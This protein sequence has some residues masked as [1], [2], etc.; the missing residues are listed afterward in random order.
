MRF[1]QNASDIPSH[2]P[3]SH[4]D[5]DFQVLLAEYSRLTSTISTTSNS[6]TESPSVIPVLLRH[7]A[8]TPS[9]L[10]RWPFP[11]ILQEMEQ[12]PYRDR[13]IQAFNDLLI[14]KD[15]N[16][17]HFSL[18]EKKAVALLLAT[19]DSF[20][21]LHEYLTPSIISHPRILLAAI[22]YSAVPLDMCLYLPIEFTIAESL[23]LKIKAKHPLLISML[24]SPHISTALT[25]LH[26]LKTSTDDPEAK[27][28]IS[29]AARS[30]DSR[31]IYMEIISPVWELKKEELIRVIFEA[32]S[33]TDNDLKAFCLEYLK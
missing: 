29:C 9:R 26:R 20:F 27:L 16:L 3:F 10:E 23:A 5:E 30:L 12:V 1:M 7:G 17:I 32:I 31:T 21:K 4:M 15:D 25:A 19:K 14:N 24:A 6:F 28:V 18:N 13:F 11:S 33:C 22:E 2:P 8:F